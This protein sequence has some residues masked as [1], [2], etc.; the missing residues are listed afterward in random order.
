M[1][2]PW[3]KQSVNLETKA[4]NINPGMP[5]WRVSLVRSRAA[6]GC[7]VSGEGRIHEEL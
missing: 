6:P 1:L 4:F 3:P 7:S 5:E 2:N